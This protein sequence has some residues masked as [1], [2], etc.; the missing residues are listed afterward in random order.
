MSAVVPAMM[1][2]GPRVNSL[3][4]IPNKVVAMPAAA[5]RRPRNNRITDIRVP[6]PGGP[7]PAAALRYGY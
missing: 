4:A 1:S 6:Q 2:V 5:T 7:P 3:I